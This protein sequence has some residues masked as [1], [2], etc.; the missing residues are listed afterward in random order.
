MF[1]IVDADRRESN[2]RN[3]DPEAAKLALIVTVRP[4]FGATP[5]RSRTLAWPVS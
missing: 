2:P 3:K 5:L 4:N 1:G